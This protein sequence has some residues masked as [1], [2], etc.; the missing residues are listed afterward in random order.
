MKIKV[1]TL[2]IGL[3]L[4]AFAVF[5]AN[6]GELESTNRFEHVEFAPAR[7][8]SILEDNTFTDPS[9]PDDLVGNLLYE[10]E[11]SNGERM[12]ARFHITR[13]GLALFREGERVVIRYAT[14]EGAPPQADLVNRD[15]SRVLIGLVLSF[16]GVLLV[17]GGKSGFKTVGSLLFTLAS[18]LLIL[19]PLILRGFPAIPTT[20]A[21]LSGVTV[22][23]LVFISGLTKQTLVSAIATLIGVFAAALA[24][25]IAGELAAING[26]ST[27]EAGFL[28]HASMGNGVNLDASGLFISG[29]LIA[30]L[31]AVLDTAVSMASSA[32][33]LALANPLMGRKQMLK[34]SYVIGKDMM[35]TMSN[36]LIL[37]FAGSSL[38]LLL[39]LSVLQIGFHEMINND[40]IGIEIIR[41]L[42]GSLGIALTVP[43]AAW[44]SSMVYTKK[45]VSQG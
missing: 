3:G 24:S 8:V 37:A 2:L 30:S 32:R 20:L 31:G 33:Q 10:V 38:N 39:T 11:L 34:A 15:R 17:L 6:S 14:W 25:F 28:I 27:E 13:A 44:L 1:L 35:G 29:V 9:H 22:L 26:F 19:N 41:S 21:I 4:F 36:T 40:G 42:A 7:V 45:D 12:E 43:A 23:V 5:F 18:I 16:L